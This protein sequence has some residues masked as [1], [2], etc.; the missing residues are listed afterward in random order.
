M[1]FGAI[2]EDK[3]ECYP[4]ECSGNITKRI[5]EGMDSVL[6]WEC[7]KCDIKFPEKE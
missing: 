5:G 3:E 6:V 1:S 7:N 4:C 2:P